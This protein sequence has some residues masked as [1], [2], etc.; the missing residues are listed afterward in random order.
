MIATLRIKIK[1]KQKKK[2]LRESQLPLPT[3]TRRCLCLPHAPSIK[4]QAYPRSCEGYRRNHILT[5]FI[6]IFIS[7]SD[8]CK[9]YSKTLYSL[10]NAD[11]NRFITTGFPCLPPAFYSFGCSR[12]LCKEQDKHQT[13]LTF[14]YGVSSWL[15][16]SCKQCFKSES[17]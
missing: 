12:A 16:G 9:V 17:E 4:C 7:T 5:I 11:G 14:T 10:P 2:R 3:V 15:L 8:Q 1:R 6:T 13:E